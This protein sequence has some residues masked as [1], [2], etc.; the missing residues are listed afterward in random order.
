MRFWAMFPGSQQP[1][2]QPQ[3]SLPP[4]PLPPQPLQVQVQVQPL[5][6]LLLPQQQKRM[7]RIRISHRQPLPHIPLLLHIDKNL[8]SKMETFPLVSVHLMR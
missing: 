8:L 1:Q 7:M 6:P 5:P 3:P 2:P 4:Q